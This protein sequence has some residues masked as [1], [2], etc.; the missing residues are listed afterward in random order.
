MSMNTVDQFTRHV[1]RTFLIIHVSAGRTK[2]ET[3]SGKERIS[4]HH[5]Q[6]MQRKHRHKK[7]HHN[8]SSWR[9]FQSQFD[10]DEVRKG[11]AHNNQ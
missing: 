11:Y 6:G 9:Y 4:I 10:E 3:Y 7:D 1:K 5:N 2:N 8:E